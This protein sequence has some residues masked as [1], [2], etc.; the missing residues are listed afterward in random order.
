MAQSFAVT[1]TNA[2]HVSMACAVINNSK[3]TGN[4]LFCMEGGRM[5]ILTKTSR[6]RTCFEGYSYL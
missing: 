6:R 3:P 2:K 5:S 4:T 1:I